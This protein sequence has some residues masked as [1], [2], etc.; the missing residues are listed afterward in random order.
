MIPQV[1]RGDP[2]KSGDYN[3]IVNAANAV[4]GARGLG[5][6]S[7]KVAREMTVSARRHSGGSLRGTICSVRNS[8]ADAW[9]AG[10]VVR[11]D[12]NYVDQSDGADDAIIQNPTSLV[13]EKIPAIVADGDIEW[14]VQRAQ[15]GIV[16][17]P[18]AAGQMSRVALSGITVAQVDFDLTDYAKNQFWYARLVP[19][20]YRMEACIYGGDAL[21]IWQDEFDDLSKVAL[22]VFPLPNFPNLGILGSDPVDGVAECRLALVD[23]EGV[24]KRRGVVFPVSVIDSVET[25]SS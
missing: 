17:E 16:L 21:I 6:V 1:N 3:Q 13:G 19:G 20:S 24:A 22:V 10:F 18:C 23:T 2:I 12:T 15:W 14:N 8:T 25:V 11:I 9:E 7:V 5:P 4:H